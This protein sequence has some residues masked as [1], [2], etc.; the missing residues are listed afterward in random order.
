MERPRERAGGS[1]LT[2]MGAPKTLER[3]SISPMPTRVGDVA[4][5]ARCGHR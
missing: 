5:E 3:S 1:V 2:S 4:T